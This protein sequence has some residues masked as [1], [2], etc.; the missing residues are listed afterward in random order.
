MNE[1]MKVFIACVIGG[2]IGT[3]I[4]LSFYKNIW[5][6]ILGFL[7]G[8][9]TGYFSY[10][11][12]VVISAVCNAWKSV[13][14]WRPDKE[15]VKLIGILF[16]WIFGVCVTSAIGLCIAVFLLILASPP[17]TQGD[18]TS[19]WMDAISILTIMA[20][21]ISTLIL[22]AVASDNGKDKEKFKKSISKM[23]LWNPFSV[24]CCWPLK[25]LWWSITKVCF[26]IVN[27]PM[28]IGKV[29]S[30]IIIFLKFIKT[31]FILIHSEARLICGVDAGIGV[32]VGCFTGQV[33]I[34]ALAGGLFGLLNYE[35]VSKRILHLVPKRT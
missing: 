13:I 9:L 30:G 4:A 5:F 14:G 29:C 18:G 25:I 1:R 3:M 28:I 26:V 20:F 31:V 17:Q 8:G 10:E 16:G 6:F 11:F 35:I 15:L 23:K 27:I 19:T 34:G 12:K 33:I 32:I 22:L 21:V 24:Y 2:G 7:V